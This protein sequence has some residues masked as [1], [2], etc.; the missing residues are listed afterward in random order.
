ML[1]TRPRSGSRAFERVP[2]S[3]YLFRV[4]LRRHYPRR[5]LD[6]SQQVFQKQWLRETRFRMT[7]RGVP[8]PP[9]AHPMTPGDGV[10]HTHRPAFV[11]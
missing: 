7:Q 2:L 11:G 10:I 6:A 1:R 9:L 8:N 4:E 5:R 3:G